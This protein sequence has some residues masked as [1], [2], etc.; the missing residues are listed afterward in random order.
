MTSDGDAAAGGAPGRPDA[1]SG[2][3]I[4]L[5]SHLIP[6]P[7]GGSPLVMEFQATV[8]TG[9]QGQHLALEQ[10]AAIRQV[11]AWIALNRHLNND[12]HDPTDC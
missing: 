2:G 5:G 1:K 12:G 8:A 4:R 11:L 10:A 9:Q 7:D 6:A 3:V